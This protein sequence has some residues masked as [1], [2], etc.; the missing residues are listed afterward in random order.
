MILYVP[1]GHYS[2]TPNYT[3]KRQMAM[4]RCRLKTS[5]TVYKY[6]ESMGHAGFG[7]NVHGW[8]PW[9]SALLP[10]YLCRVEITI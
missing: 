5:R 8:R 4:S 9:H 10:T 6:L 1:D 2:C 7:N 3:H